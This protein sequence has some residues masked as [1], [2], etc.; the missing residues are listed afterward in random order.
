MTNFAKRLAVLEALTGRSDASFVVAF[1]V[2]GASDDD[3]IAVRN[4]F[5]DELGRAPGE[6]LAELVDRM[7]ARQPLVEAHV[8]SFEYPDS[9]RERLGKDHMPESLP[10]GWP[11][12]SPPVYA[13]H[14]E[15]RI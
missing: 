3:V 2:D 15:H 10:N 14:V 11:V 7:K 12:P 9:L 5:G 8:M 4:S 6:T 1:M 13:C